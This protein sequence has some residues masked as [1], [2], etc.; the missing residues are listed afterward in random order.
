M[1]PIERR[2]LL[3]LWLG[4]SLPEYYI[5]GQPKKEPENLLQSLNFYLYRWIVHPVKRRVAKYYLRLLKKAY[6]LKVIAVTGSTGKTTTKEMIASILKRQGKTVWSEANIDP[7]FNIPTTILKCLPSTRFLVLEM[8]VEFPGE[9]DFYLWLAEPDVAV[10]TNIY[11]T[12]TLYFKNEDGVF[13]EKSKLIKFLSDKGTAVLSAENSYLK[14]LDKK[15]KSKVVWFGDTSG[16]TAKDIRLK[17]SKSTRF[18]LQTNKG[19]LFV[20]IPILG[21]QFV[22]NALAATAVGQV[23]GASLSQIKKGLQN[24]LV[25]EHRMRAIKLKSG[26]LVLD[27]SYN[28]NPQA[29]KE[30]LKTLNELDG[31]RRKIVVFGDMLELGSLEKSAHMELG[32]LIGKMDVSFLI[33][34]GKAS[35]FLVKEA[36]KTLGTNKAVLVN[37]VQEAIPL[38]KPLLLPKTVVLVKGSRSIGLDKLVS[39]LS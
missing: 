10:I 23:L 29:A 7:V 3:R 14:K 26:A 9:M 36:H 11:P 38:V 5:F 18:I 28:N 16:T 35:N 2:N 4:Y 8:G 30:A 27:D 25:P 17:D 1:K 13:E 24:F 21:K 20:R 32:K 19:K 34:V 15:I 31:F 6:K 12:H 33:G 39:E 37:S 22:Q